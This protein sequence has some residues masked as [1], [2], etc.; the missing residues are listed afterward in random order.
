MIG[1]SSEQAISIIPIWLALSALGFAILIGVISGLYPA[2]KA[3]KIRA[4]EAMRTEG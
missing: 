1:L 4:I 3:T 2:K